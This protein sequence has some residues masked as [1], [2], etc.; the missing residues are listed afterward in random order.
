MD[1]NNTAKRNKAKN[2]N[3]R[4]HNW[5]CKRITFLLSAWNWPKQ[6]NVQFFFDSL[7]SIFF[8]FEE[9]LF[10]LCV[11]KVCIKIS[12]EQFLRLNRN[13]FKLTDILLDWTAYI[14]FCSLGQIFLLYLSQLNVRNKV[15]LNRWTDIKRNIINVLLKGQIHQSLCNN[16]LSKLSF[17]FCLEVFV[18]KVTSLYF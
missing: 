4:L 13:E 15:L 18:G 11:C 14:L 12:R 5:L 3:R 8:S 17:D 9:K 2:P 6:E 1:G 16:F 7:I 10:F